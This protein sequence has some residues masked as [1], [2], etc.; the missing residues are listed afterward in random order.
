MAFFWCSLKS[1]HVGS[2]ASLSICSFIHWCVPLH[3]CQLKIAGN[4]TEG[5]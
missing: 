5:R 3:L 4:K 1:M 2:G